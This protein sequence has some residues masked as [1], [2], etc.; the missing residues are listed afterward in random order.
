MKKTLAQLVDMRSSAIIVIDMQNDFCDPKGACAKYGLD[1]SLTQDMI[2]RMQRFFARARDLG[3]QLIFVQC[4]HESSTDSETWLFRHGGVPRPLCRKGTWGA[5][6]C[7]VA[8]QGTEP[9]VIKHRYS[10][11]IGTRL[12]SV[13]KT[14]GIRTLIMTGVGTNV[15]VESTAR[16]G[17][18]LDYNVVFLSDCTATGTL[19]AHEA[20]LSNMRNH[21]GTVAT[22]DEVLAA[23]RTKVP[24]VPVA[25]VA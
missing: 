17:F 14:L 9:V 19:E 11:F 23:W 10:A 22:S 1:V 16:D 24:A 5:D 13:L 4:I 20:T 25:T 18:M 15:C 12:E 21:F 3:A 6:F 2:P 8:P 7:G